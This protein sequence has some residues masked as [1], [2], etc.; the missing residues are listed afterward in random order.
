MVNQLSIS[1]RSQLKYWPSELGSRQLGKAN[2]Q[3]AVSGM[4]FGEQI[5]G[6]GP[7]PLIDQTPKRKEQVPPDQ[8]LRVTLSTLTIINFSPV[9]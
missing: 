4:W 1:T 2:N 7:E 9:L 5:Q 6:E 8:L 3:Y